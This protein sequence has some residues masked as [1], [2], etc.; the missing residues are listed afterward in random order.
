LGGLALE[1]LD[2][3][4]PAQGFALCMLPTRSADE[5]ATPSPRDQA[6]LL[7]RG[8]C[9]IDQRQLEDLVELLGLTA[10]SQ[11]QVLNQSQI[12]ELDWPFD[13]LRQLVI[14]PLSEG[15]NLF[16][17]LAAWNHHTDCEFGTV[18]ASL[19]NSVAAILGIHSGNID[20][21]RQQR[22]LLEGIIRSLISSIDA[23]DPYTCGHSDRVA[24]IAVRL[25]KE[26]N[27]D[28]RMVE[29][30][31]LSGLLH[32]IGKIGINDAVLR[33]PGN[34]TSEEY[35][36]IK[37]H[38]SIGHRILRDLRKLDEVLPVVLHHHE[39]WDGSGYPQGLAGDAIPLSARIV[40]VADAYDAM[41]SNR[42]YRQGMPT[43][44]IEEVFRAGA[45]RQWDATIVAALFSI[46]DEIHAIAQG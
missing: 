36:H 30:L 25:A 4:I 31:Y 38:V 35:E 39:S 29:A 34:L 10:S 3:V 15:Q 7:T 28:A 5:S 18:E 9:P 20:L 43:E 19:L 27:C 41:A 21:Y 1:W 46:R 6:T 44:Q 23:K 8:E 11:P 37:T 33:K 13:S 40:S 42:P 45:G 22:E 16:G 2:D 24:R 17:Y 12:Q 26:L 14:V 32:D